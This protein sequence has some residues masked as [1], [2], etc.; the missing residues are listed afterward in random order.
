MPTITV[1]SAGETT[2]LAYTEQAPRQ[3]MLLGAAQADFD[4]FQKQCGGRMR[5]RRS[6]NTGFPTN[7]A[8]SAAGGDPGRDVAS[9]LSWSDTSQ[10][11]NVAG[12]AYDTKFTALWNSIPAG[13]RVR[14]VPWHEVNLHY[15]DFAT[16]KQAMARIRATLDASN[17]DRDLVK[18]GGLLTSS[19]FQGGDGPR[20]FDASH[21]FVGI[22]FYEFA[23]PPGSPPSPK[24]GDLG[25]LRTPEYLAGDAVALAG[26]LGLPLVVGEY[27]SHP[28]PVDP[29]D[30]KSRAYRMNATVAYI[31]ANGGDTFCW[32]HSPNGEDGPWYVNCWPDWT[33]PTDQSHADPDSVN[34]WLALLA[35]H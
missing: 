9:V 31:E 10:V 4:N 8:T 13:Q 30:P 17:A 27:A 34:A 28:F 12:G 35:S 19:G 6:Y 1:T 23:R 14:F 16:Y 24:T 22:D 18:V 20:Y 15:R 25:T 26:Q 7:Y 2:S 5:A 11:G 21:D 33:T 3:A 32:F 29:T